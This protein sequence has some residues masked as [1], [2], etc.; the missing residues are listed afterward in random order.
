[1]EMKVSE[2]M[3]LVKQLQKKGDKPPEVVLHKFT[4]GY[5]KLIKTYKFKKWPFKISEEKFREK[6]DAVFYIT[7]DHEGT[8]M[9]WSSD[10]G[11]ER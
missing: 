4:K 11:L 7:G 5:K 8:L 6:Y 3:E 1:M 2:M 10:E 9:G